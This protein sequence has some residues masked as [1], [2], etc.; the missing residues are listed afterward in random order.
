MLKRSRRIRAFL[1]TIVSVMA[2]PRM[3][4]GQHDPLFLPAVLYDTDGGKPSSVVLED[5]NGDGKLDAIVAN[6]CTLESYGCAIS[7]NDVNSKIGIML[8]NGDGTFQPV[9]AYDSGGCNEIRM[10]VGDLNGDHHPDLVVANNGCTSF[11]FSVMLGNG[12]GT[13]QP[14]RGAS[15]DGG[16]ELWAVE[17]V[18]VNNDD[19]LDVLTADACSAGCEA[20]EP[21]R[22]AIGVSLGRG[23]GT[24]RAVVNYAY[25][26][27]GP[28]SLKAADVN[29]DGT[30]D[31]L[32]TICRTTN[33]DPC[34]DSNGEILVRLGKG[35]GTFKAAQTYELAGKVGYSI[36][37]ADLNRDGK[38]DVVVGNGSIDYVAGSGS[39][40]VGVLLGNGDGTFQAAV[41][42]ASG[43]DISQFATV[44]DINQDG[45]PDIVIANYLPPGAPVGLL[46]GQGDGSFAP[47]VSYYLPN[48]VEKSESVA[49]G[50]LN[51]DGL[52]DIVIAATSVTSA[53]KMGVML[54]NTGPHHV[55]STSLLS[56]L[57]PVQPNQLVTYSAGV[58]S[59]SGEVISGTF[60]FRDGGTQGCR[61]TVVSWQC[62]IHHGLQVGRTGTCP[63][64][65]GLL[66]GRP[67]S[68]GK[69]VFHTDGVCWGLPGWKQ[70]GTEQ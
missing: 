28:F 68:R 57:N 5:V 8:G 49:L 21:S 34:S 15:G 40:I 67:V 48:P 32:A 45:A 39:G 18:D 19:V 17:L 42:F 23:D 29:G 55:S 35:D 52:L 14:A 7:S 63:Y 37:V 24:F 50:D 64:D 3:S 33:S 56:D 20:G 43:G 2:V 1:L 36:A 13:F 30:L 65:L 22:S 9:A 53:G 6:R 62:E 26:G 70:D 12:D 11:R 58:S 4:Q 38:Q 31:L 59:E 44:D 69:H 60:I 46:L 41:N 10:A 47:V 25:P 66:F 51:G 27:S 61:G 16:F 54:N